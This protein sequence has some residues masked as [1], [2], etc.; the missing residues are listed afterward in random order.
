MLLRERETGV[1]YPKVGLWPDGSHHNLVFNFFG[2]YSRAEVVREYASELFARIASEAAASSRDVLISS[3]SLAGHNR[4]PEFISAL[5][6]RMGGGFRPEIIF[7][8]REHFER[9]SSVYNQQVKDRATRERRDPADFLKARAKRLCY[10]PMLQNLARAN[11]QLTVLSYHPAGDFVKRF[12]GHVGAAPDSS[13]EAAMHN[14]SLSTKALIATLAIN[15]AVSSDLARN[16][17]LAAIYALPGSFEP[18]KSVFSTDALALTE[19]VFE[20]DRQFLHRNFDIE[21]KTPRSGSVTPFS[22]SEMDMEELTSALQ[23]FDSRADAVRQE[24]V[25]YV[26]PPHPP[27]AEEH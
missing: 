20:R 27:R 21:L 6:A 26:A 15:R 3:E 24:M 22:L 18:S 12:L 23:G 9:A 5:L 14:V 13:G 2:D 4:A 16:E 8:V 1:L 19:P 17:M 11:C 7:V 25:R 10:A